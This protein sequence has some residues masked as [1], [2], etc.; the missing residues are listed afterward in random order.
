M[1]S[2]LILNKLILKISNELE[3]FTLLG[4][5]TVLID[6]YRHFGTTYP[7]HLYDPS[8]ARGLLDPC[9]WDLLVVTKRR[10]LSTNTRCVSPQKGEDLIYTLAEAWGH[11]CI[12]LHS[13]RF[14][15]S[16]RL[17][18][19]RR[20]TSRFHKTRENLEKKLSWCHSCL[21]K[22]HSALWI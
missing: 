9:G 13:P 22:N 10:Y 18:W 21:L 7:S 14:G 4:Y 12:G 2:F 19:A 15:S 17:L 11:A 5:Y 3:I 20:W 16:G 6:S 8:S 1:R